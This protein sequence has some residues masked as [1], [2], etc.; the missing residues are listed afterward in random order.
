MAGSVMTSRRFTSTPLFAMFH[1]LANVTIVP[2]SPTAMTFPGVVP[3]I[4]RSEFVCPLPTGF[5]P[6]A[7][8]RYVMPASPTAHADVRLNATTSK[9]SSSMP[10]AYGWMS[11]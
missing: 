10:T 11:P 5:Q 7:S 2:A 9:R 4:A 6:R 3:A 8:S 1:P